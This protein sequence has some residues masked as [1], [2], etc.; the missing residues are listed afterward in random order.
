MIFQKGAFLLEDGKNGVSW[1]QGTRMCDGDAAASL[2]R[3]I[4]ECMYTQEKTMTMTIGF[5]VSIR[6]YRHYGVVVDRGIGGAITGFAICFFPDGR[7]CRRLVLGLAFT[8]QI[9]AKLARPSP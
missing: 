5:A 6:G 4:R 2:A 9:S 1:N 7:V 8:T 3:V